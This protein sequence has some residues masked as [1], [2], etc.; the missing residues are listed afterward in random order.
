MKK[1]ILGICITG[2][3]FVSAYLFIHTRP[4]TGAT[5]PIDIQYKNGEPLYTFIDQLEEKK[6]IQDKNILRKILILL[7]LDKKIKPNIYTFTEM[8]S[9][10]NVLHT[11][12]SQ[13]TQAKGVKI[14]IPEGSTNREIKA[15]ISRAFPDLKNE[16]TFLDT[17]EGYFFPDTYYLS[18]NATAVDIQTML[19]N[20]FDQKTQKLFST[21]APDDIHDI[22]TMASILEREGRG[23]DEYKMIAGILYKRIS[24]GMPLQVDA[25]FLYT[26]GKGSRDLTSN[27]LRTD[28][29]YNTYTR[30]GLPIGPIN[31]PGLDTIRAALNPTASAYLYYLHD[32]DGVIHYAKTYPEHI[33]NKNKY[34]R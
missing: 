33:R 3:I 1:L 31:N 16:L 14:V 13:S 6:I 26:L 23:I 17:D 10:M 28:N 24:I 29:P 21:I 8:Q 30:K 4:P 32:G 22:I 15:I 12:I 11:I 7:N 2:I 19:T 9:L 34:L 27:D 25:T 18:V 5:F 20:T